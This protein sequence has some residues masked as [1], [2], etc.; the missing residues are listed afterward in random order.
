M[1]TKNKT[2]LK[3]YQAPDY[4]IPE[5]ELEIDLYKERTRVISHFS[6]HAAADTVDNTSL[7][8]D[9]RNM[10]LCSITM[11][12]K[13]LSAEDYVLE[14]EKLRILNPPTEGRISIEVEI[15][16]SSN[17]EL[18][19]LYWT[20]GIFCTQN[21]P[22]GFR[23]ITYFC[24][25]PDI[26]SKYT[27]TVKADKEQYPYLLSN[28]NPIDSGE[29][30]AG[31]HF[32]TW[33]DPFPK[34]CY[35][36]ALVAG[37]FAVVEDTFTTCSGRSVDLKIFVD[38]G[39]EDR[40]VFTMDS[41]KRAMK[42]DEDTFGLEYDLD[43][44]MIV[45]VD[46]FNSGAMENK[47]LNI[48]TSVYALAD[49][50][51]A[52]DQ[53]FMLIERV[54]GHEYFHNWTGNR[55]TCRDWFQITLK[56]G[57]AI[58]RDEEFHCDMNGSSVARINMVN[59]IK[60]SQFPDDAGPLAH[61]V[62]PESYITID[63]FYTVTVYKKG[64]EIIRMIRTIIGTE[65]F[66]NG[67]RYFLSKYDGQ[68][69]TV[70]DFVSVMEEL[71]GIDL[72]QMINWY[73]QAGTPV[74]R[75]SGDYS[76]KQQKYT[77]TVE[78]SCRPTAECQNKKPYLFPLKL[79]LLDSDG[80]DMELVRKRQAQ[81]IIK[82]S[83]ILLISEPKQEFIFNDVYEE[84][85]P[86]LLRG[87]SAPVIVEYQYSVDELIFLLKYDTDIYNRY[88]AGQKLMLMALKA[89]ALDRKKSGRGSGKSLFDERIIGTYAPFIASI[90]L[91]FAFQ[92][93]MLEVPRE[94]TIV[95]SLPDFDV[96]SAFA[97]RDLL[98]A[99]LAEA[100][101]ESFLS[102]YNEFKD[103]IYDNSAQ[104]MARRSF[105]NCCLGYLGSLGEEYRE[106]VY[107]H[108]TYA[109]NLTDRLAALNI[110]ADR[111]DIYHE[112]A[113]SDYYVKWKDDSVM[114]NH[115]FSLQA[116]SNG[117]FVYDDL[118]VLENDSAYD[119]QNPTKIRNLYGTFAANLLHFHHNSGRGY[120]LIADL[121]IE[122]DS[123]NAQ[124]AARLG[125]SFN[126]YSRLGKEKKLLM[127]GQLVRILHKSDMSKN[128]FEVID[129]ILHNA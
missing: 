112:Q 76:T 13:R 63:N 83:S 49:A 36:F 101:R 118:K 105:K 64:K 93:K 30:E 110:L 52:T 56:E 104:S 29:L 65:Q 70:E 74:C 2:Y 99:S 15:D 67:I 10:E 78:Q 25:R 94:E 96:E 14:P 108:Y 57:L 68:A 98:I 45:A 24:D 113:F 81:Q 75:I 77:V 84:P 33:H 47:G 107:R 72:S 106:L 103:D 114:I 12:E 44:F 1:D 22:E 128:L 123:R 21:E 48:Y 115:W 117:A 31:R 120:K 92:A 102:C 126:H 90:S 17:S 119:A 62:R 11:G 58:Y 121:V 80:N 116:G 39:N 111:K 55:V 37:D 85:I 59:E 32:A 129:S 19:G 27:V 53:N 122:T 41:L 125:K 35:L 51:T 26:L 38:K 86:S 8:L 54:V 82:D 69:V 61:P 3:D 46:S 124:L 71:S 89:A 18:S 20:D 91:D 6:I 9:G 4:L 16:P 109:D 79:G 23:K 34:P 88:E 87:F 127:K 42:W 28:G 60:H 100:H 97:V 43:T 50:E 95:Y 40:V 73:V 66:N 5:I 7:I